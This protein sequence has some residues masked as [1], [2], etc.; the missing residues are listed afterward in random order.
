MNNAHCR[1]WKLNLITPLKFI[2]Q[3]EDWKRILLTHYNENASVTSLATIIQANKELIV[4]TDEG[5][6]TNK[7]GDVWTISHIRAK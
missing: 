5:K 7:S 3:L 1:P 6:T 2:Q 4:V